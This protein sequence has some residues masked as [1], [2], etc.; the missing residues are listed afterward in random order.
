MPILFSL[1]IDSS[2]DSANIDEELF[3]VLYFD[4]NSGSE[5]GMVHMRNNFFAFRHLSR[6]TGK[7]LYNLCQENFSLYGHDTNA[8]AV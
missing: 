7:G 1:M 5:D 6:G 2:T 4:P 8:V 3:L